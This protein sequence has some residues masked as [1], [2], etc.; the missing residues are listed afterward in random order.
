MRSE[1]IAR[2]GRGR[3]QTLRLVV[4]CEV[5]RNADG[6]VARKKAEITAG[7]LVSNGKAPGTFSA[8][9]AGETSRFMTQ[10]EL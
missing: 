4:P 10:L 9:L 6:A 2:H 3:A 8:N 5:K 1:L 7:D